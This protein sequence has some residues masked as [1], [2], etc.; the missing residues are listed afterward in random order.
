V[1]ENSDFWCGKRVLLTG[2]TG[3]KGSWLLLWLLE[4]GAEVWGYALD[5]D[6]APNLF[7]LL[8]PEFNKKYKLT[9]H[10]RNHRGD[11][12]DL[13][14][15]SRS[16]AEAQPD[17]VFHLAAQALVRTSY[18]D[19]LGTW[20]V[21]VQGSLNL[22]EAL[23]PLN[24]LCAVVMITTDKVYENKEWLY[25]Y[26]ENDPLGGHD[27]YSASKAAAEIAIASW[28]SSFCG[29]AAHQTPHLRIATARAGNVI[30]GGDWASDR[31]VPDAIRALA[32]G[33]PISVRNP[34]ATRPWQ[35]VLEPLGG[36]LRLAEALISYPDP[37]CEAFNFGPSLASNRPVRELVESIIKHWPGEWIDQSDP[38]APHEANLLHLQIDKAHHLLGWQP[39]WDYATTIS[40]T[41]GWYRA[42]HNAS[43]AMACCLADLS[44]Y[45]QLFLRE[46][47][48]P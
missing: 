13:N 11:I 5:A 23:K 29:E 35:H 46:R 40:R 44:L 28:R 33:A 22:L 41:V 18:S 34:A 25:G 39:R 9:N 3:F 17:V 20:A 26:R 14:T 24:K 48:K 47:A 19:P 31:I 42:Q 36:Y 37:P 38:N 8:E 6:S 32:I 15:L 1:I 45:Q 30:G 7:R 10:F 43:S 21:N 2:H 4:L 16:V 27:P 12:T